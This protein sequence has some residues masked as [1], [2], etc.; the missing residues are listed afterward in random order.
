MDEQAFQEG[1]ER[2]AWRN[3]GVSVAGKVIWGILG[4]GRE[5]FHSKGSIKPL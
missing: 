4:V 2:S 1:R 3:D 5:T